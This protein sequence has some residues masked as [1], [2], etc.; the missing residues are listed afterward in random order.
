MAKKDTGLKATLSLGPKV[1]LK[2]TSIDVEK[3]EADTKKIHAAPS[4]KEGKWIRV[5]TD[6][7]EE[8]FIQFKMKLLTQGNTRKGQDI[9]RE[10]IRSYTNGGQ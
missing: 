5:T 1:P 2:K 10:L 9:V 6:L 8:E 4:K 3:T 7:P